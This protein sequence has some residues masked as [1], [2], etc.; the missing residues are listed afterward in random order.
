MRQRAGLLLAASLVLGTLP[1]HADIGPDQAQAL[2]GQLRDWLRGM[3]GPQASLPDLNVTAEGDHYRLT[4]PIAP[5]GGPDRDITATLRPLDG[6]RWAADDVKL[7]ADTSMMTYGRG[8]PTHVHVTIAGQDSHGTIDPT[9]ATASTLVTGLRGI[10]VDSDTAG[11]KRTQRFDTYHQTL[12]LRPAAGGKL[13]IDEDGGA[14]GWETAQALPD[15]RAMASGARKLYGSIHVVGLDRSQAATLGPVLGALSAAPTP[16]RDER[17]R[18]LVVALHGLITSL[19]FDETIEGMQIA[20]AGQGNA[21]IDRVHFGFDSA[22][23]QGNLAARASVG[24]DGLALP[25]LSPAAA[26][27]APKHVKLGVSVAGVSASALNDLALAALLPGADAGTLAPQIDALFA[28]PGA[29][30]GPR[31]GIDTLAFDL[32]PAQVEGHGSAVAVSPTDVRGTARITVTGFD[33]LVTQMQG[34][35]SLQQVLPFLIL[36]RGM[37]RSEGATLIWDIVFTP[38]GLTVNGVDPRSLL[39]QPK[40]KPRP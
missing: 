36:A 16:E 28:D 5:L 37:S 20:V 32:G 25:G 1:A 24:L 39:G 19:T 23:P 18:A 22:A 7:P 10:A 35:P 6:G 27:L 17:L 11:Q 14:E 40:R 13:D 33:A 3:A 2:T 29:T 15:G 38:E 21:E 26:G 12:T 9:L 30:G 34:D 8:G 4:V 31:V